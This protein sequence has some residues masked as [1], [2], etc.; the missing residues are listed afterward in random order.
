MRQLHRVIPAVLIGLG[1]LV[2]T[3][4]TASAAP[5]TQTNLVS[6]IP[7]LATL[8]EPMLVNPWFFAKS[9]LASLKLARI[10]ILGFQ[11][12][13]C[14]EAESAGASVTALRSLRRLTCIVRTLP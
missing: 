1:L 11:D 14:A 12:L 13:N 3:A 2:S 6:D 8:T 5:Y 10:P 7:G 9:T 4:S